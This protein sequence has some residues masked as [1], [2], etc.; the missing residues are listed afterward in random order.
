MGNIPSRLVVALMYA[1]SWRHNHP[2]PAA[3][4]GCVFKGRRRWIYGGEIELRATDAQWSGA[5][6]VSIGPHCAPVRNATLRPE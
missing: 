4:Q 1:A 5:E 3:A 6:S 2:G